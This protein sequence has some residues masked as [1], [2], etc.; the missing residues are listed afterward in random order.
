MHLCHDEALITVIYLNF[1]Q[2]VV[3]IT[4][5]TQEVGGQVREAQQKLKVAPKLVLILLEQVIYLHLVDAFEEADNKW[6][7]L[8]NVFGQKRRFCSLEVVKN[9]FAHMSND[10]VLPLVHDNLVEVLGDLVL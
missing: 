5:L 10:A 3:Q 4:L 7:D 8:A 1:V 2:P 6:I 9:Y